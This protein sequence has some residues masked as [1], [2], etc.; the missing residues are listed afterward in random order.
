MPK[1]PLP[2]N[3]IL[4][5]ALTT[6]IFTLIFAEATVRAKDKDKLYS[7]LGNTIQVINAL[8]H[9]S[10]KKTVYGYLP[11][12][13]LNNSKYIQY[14]KLT[15]IAYF[16]LHVDNNGQFIKKDSDDNTEPG[17]NNWNTN[18]NL[19]KV[20]K[21]SKI[22][23]IRVALTLIAQDIDDIEGFLKCENCWNTLLNNTTSELKAKGIKDIN[24]DFEYAQDIDKKLTEKYTKFVDFMNKGLDKNFGDSKVTVAVFA[25][26]YKR[27]R[28]TDPTKL[29]EIADALFIMAYDFHYSG[30]ENAGP[31]APIGG[32]NS[33]YNYDIT[34]MLKDYKEHI[35]QYK[36]ILGVPY[37]GYNFLIDTENPNG[38]TVQKNYLNEHN[39][40]M[41]YAMIMDSKDIALKN[42]KWD[43]VAETPYLMYK[44]NETGSLRVLH[45]ENE[46]SLAKKYDLSLKENLLGV[47]IWAL[48]Y[49]GDYKDLWNL[50]GEK[51]KN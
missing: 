39:T 10:P 15:D 35:S 50:L 46:A 37:Y 24:L 48:G 4:Y 49:D 32:A 25:D 31:V 43:K 14:D 11:Y 9:S 44:S 47:G 29:A 40:S 36:M 20:I 22:Y 28:L 17:Y 51:F 18:E 45:F 16:G 42:T 8:F 30:S 7:P 3:I 21:L 5:I 41:Y 33:K 13:T 2:K 27:Q 6:I 26:S 1:I 23:K 19:T 38:K 34:S 12:W